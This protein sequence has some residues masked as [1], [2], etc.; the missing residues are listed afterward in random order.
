M[1]ICA[2]GIRGDGI[3][4]V[5]DCRVTYEDRVLNPFSDCLLKTVALTGTSFLCFA[6]DIMCAKYLV[7]GLNVD[8][9][10]RGMRSE[11]EFLRRISRQ[12]RNAYRKYSVKRP[13]QVVQLLMGIAG[14][15][16]YWLGKCGSPD[17]KLESTSE[18]GRAFAIGGTCRAQTAAVSA[19]S[20]ALNSSFL[21]DQVAIVAAGFVD[22][23]LALLYPDNYGNIAAQRHGVSSLFT[24]FRFTNDGMTSFPYATDMYRGSIADRNEGLGY[25][26][27]NEVMLDPTTGKF[28]LV[29][30][31]SGQT[32]PLSE[33]ATFR[34][35]RVGII[36]TDFNP[37][38]LKA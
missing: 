22:G 38:L 30:H 8:Y 6:G 10:V 5:S 25:A 31:Q 27:V 12:L 20:T 1:T 4:V 36:R 16:R 13:K 37:Y 17:F 26:R 2:A 3:Y 14:P 23:G 35:Q 29:D 15:G 9:A 21:P 28:I 11:F 18:V 34:G 24:L 32:N 19:I 7:S 33:L